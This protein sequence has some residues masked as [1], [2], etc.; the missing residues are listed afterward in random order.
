MENDQAT[1]EAFDG[2]ELRLLNGR[3]VRC[4]ALTIREAARYLRVLGRLKKE[5]AQ[6]DVFMA[7]FPE[8]IGLLEVPLADLGLAVALPDGSQV[9]FGLLTVAD[10]F[11]MLEVLGTALADPFAEESSLAKIRVLDEFPV[12]L[13][14][15]LKEPYEVFAL[16]RA[17]A[18]SF[19]LMIY[20]LAAD[21]LVHLTASPPVKVFEIRAMR[22][23]T[24]VSM[25]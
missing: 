3:T 12:T 14:V 24:P 5:P 9:K 25:T 7:E 16:G 17:F 22:S 21:F 1:F 2:V 23:P 11:A 10:A 13:G 8:R 6:H 15:E 18:E 20:G 4:P 19:Y